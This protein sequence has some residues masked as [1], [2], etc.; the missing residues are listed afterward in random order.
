MLQSFYLLVALKLLCTVSLA[1]SFQSALEPL[2]STQGFI[3]VSLSF[4]DVLV[5]LSL[6]HRYA[7]GKLMQFVH[8]ALCKKVSLLLAILLQ[9]NHSKLIKSLLETF[10]QFDFLLFIEVFYVY[11]CLLRGDFLLLELYCVVFL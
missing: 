7:R 4:Q 5:T 10:L 6:Q 8:V 2:N 11:E 3:A 1:S 9:A